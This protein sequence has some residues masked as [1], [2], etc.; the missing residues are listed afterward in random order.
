MKGGFVG[1]DVFFVLSGFLITQL[2]LSGAM[3]RGY[4]SLASFYIRRGRRILPAAALTLV[5]TD[6]VALYVLNFVRAKE[7]AHDSIWA[8]LFAANIRFG[9]Q[10]TDYFARGQPP[11][12]VQHFWSLAVEEQFYLF[13]PV[14]LALVLFGVS[15]LLPR[16]G[17]PSA[18][19]QPPARVAVKRLGVAVGLIGTLSLAW[20][21]HDTSAHPTSAFFSTPARAWELALGAA[22]AVAA[23]PFGRCLARSRALMGWFGLA[24]IGL[25][26]VLFSGGT[27]IPGYAALARIVREPAAAPL[28]GAA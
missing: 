14:V 24:G 12:P 22:L 17:D 27:P 4:V 6:V 21:I 1:V 19:L 25:A 18:I 20:S 10:G 7:I 11:S 9:D 16:H 28:F 23:A 2:L 5:V 8:S 13:W 15:R 3:S 26:G